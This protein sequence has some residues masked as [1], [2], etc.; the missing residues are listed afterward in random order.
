[1]PK[2][3][4]ENIALQQR[5][6][7]V[8]NGNAEQN[9]K[10]TA[11]LTEIRTILNTAQSGLPDNEKALISATSAYGISVQLPSAILAIQ[12]ADNQ[13]LQSSVISTVITTF[14]AVYGTGAI[15][16]DTT[17]QGLSD[18]LAAAVAADRAAAQ[19]TGA[20]TERTSLLT[21]ANTALGDQNI[22]TTLTN[23]QAVAQLPAAI[24]QRSAADVTAAEA[25][26][27]AEYNTALTSIAV[28]AESALTE[29]ENLVGAP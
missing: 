3:S 18:A 17:L 21:A 14:N 4:A 12:T 22:P 23:A 15:P 26:L 8:N 28:A 24:T 16:G 5:L 1:M 25:A 29:Y 7:A 20:N 11:V 27:N 13:G 19:V 6:I 2:T 9:A 10:L